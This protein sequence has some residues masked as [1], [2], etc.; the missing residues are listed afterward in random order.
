MFK[1]MHQQDSLELLCVLLD[2]VRTEEIGASTV[3]VAPSLIAQSLALIPIGQYRN[4]AIVPIKAHAE[5]YRRCFW[6]FDAQCCRLQ[7]LLPPFGSS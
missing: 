7:P 3:F 2:S 5:F 6:W 4:V 1:D